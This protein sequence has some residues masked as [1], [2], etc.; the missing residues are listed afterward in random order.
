MI[1][2]EYNKTH[3]MNEKNKLIIWFLSK[4]IENLFI[5]YLIFIKLIKVFIIKQIEYNNFENYKK[6][7]FIDYKYTWNEKWFSKIFMHEMNK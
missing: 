6:I 3:S 5:K 7:L 1:M 2:I 4:K